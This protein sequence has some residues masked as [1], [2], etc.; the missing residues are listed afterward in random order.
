MNEILKKIV[1]ARSALILEE[2]FFATL[3]LKLQIEENNELCKTIATNGI[4]LIYNADFIEKCTLDE[5]KALN[6]HEVLHCV[7]GHHV[8]RGNRDA[9]I[10]NQAADYVINPIL[11]DAGFVLPG[12]YLYN[13]DF[14]GKT[15]DEVYNILYQKQQQQDNKPLPGE[16]LDYTGNDET[17][18]EASQSEKEL[19]QQEWQIAAT[20]AANQAKACGKLPA[21]LARLISDLNESKVNW[22]EALHRFV[23]QVARN[24]YTWKRPNTR[25]MGTGFILPSLYNHE[26]PPLDIYVDTSGSVNQEDLKQFASEI[27]DILTQYNTTARVIYCDTR[28]TNVEEFTSE[29]R[30]VKLNAKGGGGTDFA[31]AIAWSMKQEDLPCCGVY[32]TDLECDSFGDEPDFPVLW[33]ATENTR[34]TVPWGELVKMHSFT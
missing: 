5:T 31:P 4:K 30:P 13:K 23:E 33:V 20:Q 18:E 21:S 2:S 27:D 15:T 22:R 28:V 32:L 14:L 26:M 16:V 34:R 24:D 17:T 1:K 11:L 6:A 12:E 25:Y 8:N 9:K 3:A 10:Y 7:F 29:N 19:Q